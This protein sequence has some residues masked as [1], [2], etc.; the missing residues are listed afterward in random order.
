MLLEDS[1]Q[2][3]RR[4]PSLWYSPL[5]ETWNREHGLRGKESEILNLHPI[6]SLNE[7]EPRRMNYNH[8]LPD[9]STPKLCSPWSALL[10]LLI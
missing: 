9:T 1:R 2:V 7:A 4:I 6:N 3:H 8:I 5:D 10:M